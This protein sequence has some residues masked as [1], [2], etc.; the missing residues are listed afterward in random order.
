MNANTH[1]APHQ[2]LGD[3]LRE[4]RER[5]APPADAGRRRTPGLRREEVAA[6]AGVSVTW[7]TWLEQGRGGAPSDEALERLSAALELDPG[8]RELLFLLGRQRPP[9]PMPP[10]AP[11]LPPTL[12][13]VLDALSPCPAFV[14]SATWDVLAWNT[15]AEVVLGSFESAE[16]SVNVLRRLFAPDFDRQSLPDWEENARFAVSVFRVDTLRPGVG[17]RAAEL[18]AELHASSSDFRRI[19]AENEL[20]P[21]KAGGKRIAHPTAGPLVFDVSTFLVDGDGGLTMVVFTPRSAQDRSAI[22]RLLSAAAG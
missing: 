2:T 19:W 20:K 21:S 5:L 16:T 15:A 14:K 22:E 10:A 6:R 13:P 8:G 4:R 1:A 17:S 18:A 11:T 7:Y 3:F 12:Q 9:P